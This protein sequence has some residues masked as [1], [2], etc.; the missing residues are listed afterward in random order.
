[1]EKWQCKSCNGEGI[2]SFEFESGGINGESNCIVCNGSGLE[3]G[4]TIE[5]CKTCDGDG[6]ENE[7]YY[8]HEYGYEADW[9]MCGTC[10]GEGKVIVDKEGNIV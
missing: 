10:S 4:Y 6:G 9:I 5:K 2:I 1:M 7:E 3:K 8:D